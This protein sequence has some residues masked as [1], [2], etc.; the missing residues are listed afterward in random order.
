MDAEQ[1]VFLIVFYREWLSA[2]VVSRCW[3]SRWI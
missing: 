3:G 1:T 2:I